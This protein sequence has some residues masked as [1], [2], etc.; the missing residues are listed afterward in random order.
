MACLSLSC[1]S[2]STISSELTTLMD[3]L[4]EISFFRNL[5]SSSSIR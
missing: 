3:I 2:I 1:C 5:V 4:L